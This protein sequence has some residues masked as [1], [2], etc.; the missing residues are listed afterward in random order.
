MIN[1]NLEDLDN[2]GIPEVCGF[3]AGEPGEQHTTGH[4]TVAQWVKDFFE[5]FVWAINCATQSPDPIIIRR[6]AGGEAE[7]WVN[8]NYSKDV[9]DQ[10]PDHDEDL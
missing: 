4:V 7:L 8:Q 2:E 6:P 3:N 1:H 5:P 9:V 10:E